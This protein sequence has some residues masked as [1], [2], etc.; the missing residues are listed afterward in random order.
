ML[1][2]EMHDRQDLP[3]SIGQLPKLSAEDASRFSW[4]EG[5]LGY[6][7]PRGEA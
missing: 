5:Q 7:K 3:V 1:T 4:L 2:T 6:S